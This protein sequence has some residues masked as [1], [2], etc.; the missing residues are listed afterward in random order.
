MHFY[1]EITEDTVNLCNS[2]HNCGEC[3]QDMVVRLRSLPNPVPGKCVCERHSGMHYGAPILALP[4]H[5][6]LPGVRPLPSDLP[7]ADPTVAGLCF[8]FPRGLRCGIGAVGA[9]S[10]QEAPAHYKP[11]ISSIHIVGSYHGHRQPVCL[12]PHH[13]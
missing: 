4:H 7:L 12:P 1:T 2:M 11:S 5:R 3:V 13:N 9:P 8:G 10:D 6:D